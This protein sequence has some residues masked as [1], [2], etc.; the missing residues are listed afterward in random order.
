MSYSVGFL[1]NTSWRFVSA[2]Y[3]FPAPT[4]PWEEIFPECKHVD[5]SSDNAVVADFIAIK[6]GDLNNSVDNCSDFNSGGSEDRGG[7]QPVSLTIRCGPVP[8]TQGK[9][10]VDFWID[11]PKDLV[12]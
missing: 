8:R 2:D 4:D 9:A 10:T 1:Q 5:L 6:I 3:T 12:S 7:G 11:S